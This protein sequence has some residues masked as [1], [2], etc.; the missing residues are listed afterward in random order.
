[1]RYEYS[2]AGSQPLQPSAEQCSL[3]SPHAAAAAAGFGAMF[4]K[5]TPSENVSGVTQLKSSVQRGIRGKI[6]E[7]FPQLEVGTYIGAALCEELS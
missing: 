3:T 6:A 2:K 5:F 1:L 4:R 7:Q